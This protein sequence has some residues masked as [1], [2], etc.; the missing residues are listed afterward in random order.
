MYRGMRRRA[1][2]VDTMESEILLKRVKEE[3]VVFL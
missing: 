1:I 2:A 3:R